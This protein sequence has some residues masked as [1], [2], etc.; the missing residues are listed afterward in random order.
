MMKLYSLTLFRTITIVG[1]STLTA[2]NIKKGVKIF[3][4]TG[5]WTGPVDTNPAFS[6]YYAVSACNTSKIYRS[7]NY[8]YKAVLS[9]AGTVAHHIAL[10]DNMM[11]KGY[12]RI[13]IEANFN[14]YT[15][16]V[17]TLNG[18]YARFTYKESDGSS[19]SSASKYDVVT[20]F[21]TVSKVTNEWVFSN[22]LVRDDSYNVPRYVVTP[23]ILVWFG[24]NDQ[25]YND[26]DWFQMT[27]WACWF[28][29]S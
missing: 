23:Q 10:M 14:Y 3:N 24:T 26:E 21:D 19:H 17:Y 6:S 12:T 8:K 2:G 27:K 20:R 7:S 13:W 29:K 28:S 25:G 1:S 22:R 16:S 9:F 15:H 5:T 11:D 4:V 18:A